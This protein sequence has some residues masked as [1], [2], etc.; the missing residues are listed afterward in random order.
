MRSAG[1]FWCLAWAAGLAPPSSLD[2]EPQA[3][4]VR[5]E[6]GSLPWGLSLSFDA[7]SKEF[8]LKN[9]GKRPAWFFGFGPN[10][11]VTSVE[12]RTRDGWVVTRS[13]SCTTGASRQRLDP[14]RSIRLAARLETAPFY[15]SLLD[16]KARHP[17]LDTLPLRLNLLVYPEADGDDRQILHGKPMRPPGQ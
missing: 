5:D 12:R 8:I 15:E 6:G 14:G 16:D 17:D 10:S 4:A 11:P 9:Q 2:D 13:E 7:N 1:V 3:P